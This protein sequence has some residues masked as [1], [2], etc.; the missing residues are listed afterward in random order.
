M[1]DNARLA[2]ACAT[3]ISMCQSIEQTQDN[4]TLGLDAPVADILAG[5]V[6]I[7]DLLRSA[8][9]GDYR[10]FVQRMRLFHVLS[11]EPRILKQLRAEMRLKIVEAG[12]DPDDGAIAKE[13]GHK[14]GS[15]RFSKLAEERAQTFNEQ[16]SLLSGT[17]F[18]TCLEQY[19]ALIAHVEKM[20][21]DGCQFYTLGNYPL[22]TF[23]SIL[24]IEEV[25]KLARLAQDLMFYDVPGTA[26][27]SVTVERSHRRKHFIGVVSGALINARLDR[28]LGKDVIRK[29]LHQAESDEL[30]KI[31]QSCLYIDVQGGRAVIPSAVI[32]AERAR[33]LTVLAGELMAEVLGHFPW[34]FERM[35]ENVIAFERAIGMPEKK[36]DRR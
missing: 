8:P 22:A 10:A 30:E 2:L 13:L 27:Q 14:D 1:L 20:W 3:L 29:I 23:L 26:S 32:D 12:G 6:S 28:V 21:T 5:N 18:E 35:L 36:I 4:E 15:R 17:T 24:V 19:K 9:S 34:E 33:V 11:H 16:P 31:R 7:F 25:G